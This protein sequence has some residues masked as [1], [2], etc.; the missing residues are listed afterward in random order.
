M[1]LSSFTCLILAN[2]MLVACGGGSG[3][4]SNSS[5][6]ISSSSILSVSSL[7]SDVSTSAS[8]SS[9]LS[10]SSSSLSVSS[11]SSNVSTSEISSSNLSSSSSE[12]QSS[13]TSS[14]SPQGCSFENGEVFIDQTCVGVS[15]P[16]S[17]EF[18]KSDNSGGEEQ[19]MGAEGQL[20]TQQIL[21][22]QEIGHH[23]VLDV[24]YSSSNEYN[25]GVHF[26]T[27]EV[28]PVDLTGYA[29]SSLKF[30]VKV[31][32]LG[33]DQKPLTFKMVC[34]WPC[35]STE[36]LIHPETLGEWQTI[37]V[38]L[39]QLVMRGLDLTKVTAALEVMP[40]WDHQSD[41][42]FQL[43]NIRLEVD[44][45]LPAAN[46]CYAQHF[47]RNA[48]TTTSVAGTDPHNS[49]TVISSGPQLTLR[50]T[51]V[52]AASEFTYGIYDTDDL[53]PC[54]DKGLLSVDI[55][56]PQAYVDDGNLQLALRVA[57]W[58][59]EVN[60]T[61]VSAADLKGDDWNHLEVSLDG[62]G[63]PVNTN[64][65]TINF[66]PNGKPT[67]VTGDFIIDNFIITQTSSS[68]STSSSADL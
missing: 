67:E 12:L 20:I 44:N 15:E 56:V 60:F 46:K 52:D 35:E 41:A 23:Q 24:V 11:L 10:S 30:D 58:S 50:P 4:S 64:T 2:L 9:A 55:F 61:P 54:V 39:S 33:T 63:L 27:P 1:K 13:S 62:A 18:K 14:W 31:I 66:I 48:D 51:W 16:T 6:A 28:A 37:E 45:L 19:P 53:A 21:D 5:S 47:D 43:D 3:S 49:V 68:S 36:L 8:S 34:G 57:A 29:T 65:L 40:T 59:N 22:T 26:L 7:S 42:H 38:P 17:Y 32:D 25:G